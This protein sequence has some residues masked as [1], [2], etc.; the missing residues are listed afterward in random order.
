MNAMHQSLARFWIVVAAIWI[1]GG[2]AGFLYSQQQDIPTPLALAV[3]PAILVELT[4]YAAMGVTAVRAR[5]RNWNPW[6]IVLV[7]SCSAALPHAMY[8]LASGTFR[9]LYTAAVLALA[10]VGAAWFL[11]LPRNRFVDLAFLA[12]IAFVSL[13]PV[14]PTLY[15]RPAPRLR[16]EFLGG[17]MWIR[18]TVLAILTFRQTEEI[19]F[20]FWPR[21]RDWHIGLVH[22]ALFV[23]I[24][25]GLGLLTGFLHF[26]P[27]GSGP[28]QLAA[29]LF[30][31]FFG[32][33]WVVALS[34][35][36]W[37]RGLLQQWLERWL[38]SPTASLVLTSIVFGLVH[39]PYR[40]FPNWRFALLA[41][42][43]GLFYGRAYQQARGIRAPMVTHALVVTTW[44]V[45]F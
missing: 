16:L 28:L 3:L 33:L 42:L 7:L 35:E 21:K 24:G 31:T 4:L 30:G 29:I 17:L 40:S 13:A 45:L 8:T 11:I 18:T 14:F 1:V 23:P 9:P 2:I 44:R 15:P 36:F 37:F 12:L 22:Y 38:S 27:R 39:L 25:F 20:G 19:E 26:E 32:I 43:A 10:A 34:E 6:H 41:G 5:L